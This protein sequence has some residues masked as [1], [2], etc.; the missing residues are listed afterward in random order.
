MSSDPAFYIV[1][2]FGVG[3]DILRFYKY[4][5]DQVKDGC[6]NFDIATSCHGRRQINKVGNFLLVG[7]THDL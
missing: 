2:E 6:L 1:Y 7:I 4:F 5:V 3:A